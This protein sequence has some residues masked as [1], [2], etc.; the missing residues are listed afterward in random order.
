VIEKFEVKNFKCHEGLNSFSFPGLTI[1]S[2]T[3]NSGKSSLLQSLYLL[4][5]SSN[6]YCPVLALNNQLKLG[7]FADILNNEKGSSESIEFTVYFQRE[8]VIE[9]N[10]NGLAINFVYKNPCVL[11]NLQYKEGNPVLLEI[12]VEEEIGDKLKYMKLNL[13]DEYGD[14][15]Y[16]ISGDIE[17]GYCRIN[18][19]TPQLIIY[20]DTL[21]SGRKICC[22]EF[23][24]ICKYI[25]EINKGRFKYLR[26]YRVDDYRETDSTGTSGIGLSGEFTAEVISNLWHRSMDYYDAD[27]NPIKFSMLFDFWTEKLIGKAYK[28]RSKKI[29]RNKY[30]LVIQELEF[31]KELNLSQV[32]F[33]ISQILPVLT[34]I[35]GS[36][37][38]DVILIENPEIH[39]HPKLQAD[40]VDLFIFALKNGRKIIIE[41]HSEHII[42]RMRLR[43]K[44]NNEL[45]DKVNIYF[46]EKCNEITKYQSIEVDNQGK[47]NYWPK[48]FFDE[49]YYDLLGLLK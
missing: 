14:S 43:L 7:S 12:N 13:V 18:G 2:G 6:I 22:K 48:D 36:L 10:I 19:I 3:N 44:E 42:N 47:I 25:A 23:E 32:G 28:V 16:K 46:F 30:K 33:G 11:K 34:L 21:A 41:T 40:L 5:Q 35:L 49:G 39:L 45:L 9:D 4:T 24:V 8:L 38:N 20:S 17:N 31:N 29:D 1:I 27:M 15:Y 37:K 26:A